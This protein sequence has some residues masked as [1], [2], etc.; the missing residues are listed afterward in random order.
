MNNEKESEIRNKTVD[1]FV[2]KIKEYNYCKYR[3][4]NFNILTCSDCC[5]CEHK[6]E[7]VDIVCGLDNL[8]EYFK[9]SGNNE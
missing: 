9:R 8:A 5:F 6:K 2:K 3:G 7:T 4:I 1:E